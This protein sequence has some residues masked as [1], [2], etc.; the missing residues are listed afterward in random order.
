MLF[1]SSAQGKGGIVKVPFQLISCEFGNLPMMVACCKLELVLSSSS[2]HINTGSSKICKQ[3]S[4]LGRIG[5]KQNQNQKQK[6][7]TSQTML[8]PSS[9]NGKLT[10]PSNIILHTDRTFHWQEMGLQLMLPVQGIAF[11]LLLRYHGARACHEHMAKM[12]SGRHE[13]HTD[14]FHLI[15]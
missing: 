2:D 12:S 5:K 7:P 1:P 9:L 4:C 15:I 13:I 3:H 14:H 8:P 6:T 10:V 11:R